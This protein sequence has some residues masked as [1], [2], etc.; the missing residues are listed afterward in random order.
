MS[1]RAE[2]TKRLI[3]AYESNNIPWDPRLATLEEWSL[4]ENAVYW[5]RR[6]RGENPYDRGL[7]VRECV[8]I[9]RSVGG[10]PPAPSSAARRVARTECQYH[11]SYRGE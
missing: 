6:F 3:A 8:S 1:K 10:P 9:L 4:E 2:L 5:E 11:G 7:T